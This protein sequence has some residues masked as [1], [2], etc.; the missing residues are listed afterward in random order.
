VALHEHNG[1]EHS[2]HKKNNVHMM[3]LMSTQLLTG[4]A[5]KPLKNIRHDIHHFRCSL[6]ERGVQRPP[7]EADAQ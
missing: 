3:A 7:F 1:G 6:H 5:F 2:D 4:Y